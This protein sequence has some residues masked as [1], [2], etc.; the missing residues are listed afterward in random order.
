M[1]KPQTQDNKNITI[2]IP[3]QAEYFNERIYVFQPEER[4]QKTIRAN[5]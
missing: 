5:D 4:R 3:K 1:K 2:Q